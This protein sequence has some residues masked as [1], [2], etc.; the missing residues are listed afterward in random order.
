M[1]VITNITTGL[2]APSSAGAVT[3]SL[4]I[5][6]LSG[7]FTIKI[8][9][10]ELTAAKTVVFALEDTV[11]AYSAVI[12]HWVVQA[13]GEIKQ[14]ADKVFSIKKQDIPAF[15]LGTSSAAC[16]INMLFCTS[17]PGVKVHAWIEQ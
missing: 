16:R 14:P 9:I 13:T 5:S 17:T 10:A 4:D 3:G 2:Q 8:R 6:G 15:R 7:D 1:A 11:D 12:T